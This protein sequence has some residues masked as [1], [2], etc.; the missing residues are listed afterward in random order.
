M[1]AA[2]HSK[3]TSDDEY[4]V[5][6]SRYG[7]STDVNAQLKALESLGLT[8]KFITTGSVDDL[9]AEIDANRP[10][11]VGW[12]H[13]GSVSHP[14]GGGHWTVVIGYY[15]DGVYM[16]DPNGEADLVK[17]G[18]TP[19]YN[20]AGLKYSYNNWLPRWDVEGHYSGWY[21]TCS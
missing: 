10:V 16:N 14:S 21:L 5:I 3:V 7:D 18:Y 20:G 15:S 9:K 12:L 6:R 17:G 11:A 19:N 8:A 2:Y 13:K 4:N 1:L